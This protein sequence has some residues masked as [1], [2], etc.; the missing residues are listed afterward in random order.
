MIGLIK[1][2]LLFS[3]LD[4]GSLITCQCWTGDQD[5]ASSVVCNERCSILMSQRFYCT[6]CLKSHGNVAN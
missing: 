2:W 5:I 4:E 6:V 1:D 3:S